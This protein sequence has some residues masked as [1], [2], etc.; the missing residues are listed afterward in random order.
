MYEKLLQ[1]AIDW[2]IIVFDCDAKEGII[3]GRLIELMQSWAKGDRGQDGR[4]EHESDH[5]PRVELIEWIFPPDC[6]IEL[7]VIDMV[8]YTV[9]NEI[10]SQTY[11]NKNCCFPAKKSNI[12]MGIGYQYLG[13]EEEREI[14]ILGAF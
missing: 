1:Q 7:S 6:A 14:A 3:S 5:T 13:D 8:G 10:S 12:I 11:K 2:N 9:S 4:D